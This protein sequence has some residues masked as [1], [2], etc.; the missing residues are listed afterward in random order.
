M[1][2]DSRGTARFADERPKISADRSQFAVYPHTQG[3]PSN[4]VPSI[5]NR[6][7]SI[8]ADAEIPAGGADGVLF[9]QGGNDGGLSLYVQDGRLRF[10]YNYVGRN[11]Y[12]IESDAPVP[13]GRHRLRFEFEVTGKPDIATGKGAP[14]RGQLYIDDALVGQTEIPLTNPLNVG[15]LSAFFCGIDSGATVTPNYKSPF[16]F[17]G[18]IHK[19][20]V[21][22]SGEL[23]KDDDAAVRMVLARQ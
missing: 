9:S 19:V 13:A 21:D 2:V 14:G 15:L 3:I 16:A 7:Y 17:T 20:M 11:I 1:P 22:V 4:A 18:T 23:I 8:T 10:A 5:L 12:Y 6:P